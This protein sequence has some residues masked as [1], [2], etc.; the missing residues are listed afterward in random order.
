MSV[1]SLLKK[2]NQLKRLEKL[3]KAMSVYYQIL[4]TSSNLSCVYY[5]LGSIYLKKGDLDEAIAQFDR[6]IQI[7]P[8]QASYYYYLGKVFIEQ[9]QL[10][11]ARKYFQKAIEIQPSFHLAHQALGQLSQLKEEFLGIKLNQWGLPWDQLKTKLQ[12]RTFVSTNNKYLYVAVPKSACTTLKRILQ[13]IE[14]LEQITPFGGKE[15]KFVM[16]IHE[17]KFLPNLLELPKWKAREIIHSGEYFRFTFVRNPYSRLYSCWRTKIYLVEPGWPQKIVANIK[18]KFP[19]E[20]VGNSVSFS[21]FIKYIC[22]YTNLKNCNGHWQTQS[23]LIFQDAIKYDLI[24]KVENFENDIECFFNF[25]DVDTFQKERLKQI[26]E[27]SYSNYKDDWR[28]YY[29]EELANLVYEA[30]EEDFLK[31]NY[32][33]DSWK[34]KQNEED[35]YIQIGQEGLQQLNRMKIHFEKEIYERNQTINMLYNERDKLLEKINRK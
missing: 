10:E 26:K 1:G 4:E 28:S 3:D 35:S 27:N 23:S 5:H 11:E 2:A 33:K 12:R 20:I 13:K 9:N 17:T 19:N 32:S 15:S 24:G 25:I 34:Q 7:N 18:K 29:D 8:K 6:A 14:K 30:Y 22:T 16:W 21:G 31:F